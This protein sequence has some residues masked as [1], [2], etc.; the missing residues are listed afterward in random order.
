[1]RS[2][3]QIIHGSVWIGLYIL[4]IVAPFLVLLA[5]QSPPGR[6]FWREVAVGLGFAGLSM[7]G[8]QFFLTGRFQFIEAPYGID[9]VY[10]FH[11]KFP[12]WMGRPILS[13]PLEEYERCNECHGL[14]GMAPYPLKHL[15]W[16]ERSC[17]QCHPPGKD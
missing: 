14:D 10:H 8:L 12:V 5:G 13:H 6:G 15:G 9:V 17:L 1:M 2:Q 7:M 4:I 16:S 11:R 3:R